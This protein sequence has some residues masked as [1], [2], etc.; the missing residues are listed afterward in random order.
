MI[1]KLKRRMV[2]LVLAGLLLASA[3]LVAAINWMNWRSLDAQVS[4]VLDM[5]ADNGGQRPGGLG[6]GEGRGFLPTGPLGGERRDMRRRDFSP[7]ENAARL[8]T[9]YTIHLD[10]QGQVIRWDSDRADIY[11]DAEIAELAR[12]ILARGDAAGRVD[13]QFYRR[14]EQEGETLLIVVDARMD[15]QNARSVLRV[16]LLVALAETA[17]LGAGALLLIRRMVRPVEE[18]MDKQKQFVWDASHELKTP[19]AVISANAQVLAQEAGNSQPLE[20]IQ[21]E[22]KRTDHLIQNLLTLARMEKSGGAP[23]EKFDL[24]RAVTRVAL[25]F[26]PVLFEAGKTLETQVA[27][28]IWHTGHEEMIQQLV[29]ILLS[30]AQKYSDAHGR[31]TLSLTARGDKRILK[32]H[33]TGPAI[34]KEAQAKIFDRFY[35]ADSSH[36]REIPGNGLGLAIAQSIVDAHRGKISVSSAEGEGTTF[37]VVL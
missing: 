19:L 8:S 20:Y 37:T 26:E 18:A 3:G 31:V 9:F 28:N 10:A 22:V 2:L 13:T 14:V 4:G 23:H 27:E 33:N 17:L 36:N 21:A 34:P 16:T 12:T 7:L 11:T 35:R 32:V 15:I 6:D 30:N 29:T 1:Q 5:L 24:S 25:A